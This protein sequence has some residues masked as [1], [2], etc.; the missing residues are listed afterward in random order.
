M[1]S[2]LLAVEVE[3]DVDDD[4]QVLL[5]LIVALIDGNEDEA[6]EVPE[7]PIKV[8]MVLSSLM[9]LSRSMAMGED[10]EIL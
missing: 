5:I 2:T 3:E 6:A 9:A 8:A 7:V 4:K 10:G 1:W